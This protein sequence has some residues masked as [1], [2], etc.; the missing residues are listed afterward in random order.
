MEVALI[1]EGTYPYY[2]GG[3]S[4]WCDQLIQGLGEHHFHVYPLCVN[5]KEK[6][7]W[8]A[9][10]NLVSLRPVALWGQETEWPVRGRI[11]SDFEGIHADFWQALTQPTDALANP[12]RP[13]FQSILQRMFWYAQNAPLGEALLSNESLSRLVEIWYE[14]GEEGSNPYLTSS[15]EFTLSD[16][17]VISDLMEHLLRPL[18]F[19]PPKVDLT[20]MAMNGLSALMGM[21]AKWAHG[22]PM[23]MSEHGIYLRERYLSYIHDQVPHSV[24][25]LLLNFFR[26]LVSSAYQVADILTPHSRYNRR[27]QLQNGATPNQLWVMY[28]G[29]DPAEFPPIEEEPAIPTISYMGRVDPLKDLHTLIRSFAEVKRQIPEAKLRMFGP[30]PPGNEVYHE[31][32]VALIRELGIEGSAHFEGRVKHPTEA[33]YA[34]NVVVMSSI[35]EGFPYT[36]VEAMATGKAVVATN[37]GGIAEAV[38]E[39]DGAAGFVVS[40]RDYRAMAGACVEL[41]QDPR[42]RKRYGK[43]ARAR[44][45]ARFTLEQSINEYRKV[46]EEALRGERSYNPMTE[47]LE[48]A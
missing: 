48:V 32:C 36:L 9:P 39:G 46:Y 27:W 15:F 30:I 2:M 24:K 40:P 31:S 43:N 11:P 35:S 34:G 14:Y 41:L 17:L 45:L 26:L 13:S 19:A 1:S 3:V 44:V 47:E 10:P 20:H 25:M 22:T 18:S 29:V 37:V 33:Y 4:V 42:A 16:A 38:G 21:T 28:N 12:G 5:G 23:I 7:I 8:A 6:V